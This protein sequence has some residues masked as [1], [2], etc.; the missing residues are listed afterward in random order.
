M[1][2]V[3]I[4]LSAVCTALSIIG[5]S[6]SVAYYKKS[7]QLTIYANT[8]IVLVEIQKIISTLTE[9]LELANKKITP[10]GRNLV[11]SVTT[12]GKIFTGFD[13]KASDRSYIR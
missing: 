3:L 9:L 2:Y 5:A 10:R 12:N 6:K 8:N 1:D 7:K 11:K 13:G 4:G